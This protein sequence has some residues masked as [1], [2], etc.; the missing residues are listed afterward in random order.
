MHS[1]VDSLLLAAVEKGVLGGVDRLRER[2]CIFEML[3][4]FLLQDL[5]DT[6]LDELALFTDGKH[7]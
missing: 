3:L 4:C 1:R 5:L 7:V 6:L 2:H